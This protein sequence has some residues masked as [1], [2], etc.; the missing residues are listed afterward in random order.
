MHFVTFSGRY[1]LKLY[2]TFIQLHGKTFDY[3]IPLSSVLR[4]F[5]LPQNE[6][7]MYFVV[8]R[9]MRSIFAQVFVNYVGILV[10]RIMLFRKR[11]YDDNACVAQ[12]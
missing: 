8:S 3:K 9:R 11:K 12:S 10:S 6:R 7:Q 4:M 5:L 1:D 2:P